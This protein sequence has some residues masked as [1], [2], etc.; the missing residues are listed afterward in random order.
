[1]THHVTEKRSRSLTRSLSDKFVEPL[2]NVRPLS[3]SFL[4]DFDK[5]KN[6]ERES[7]R[8]NKPPQV[9]RDKSKDKSRDHRFREFRS[10]EKSVEK[11]KFKYHS[12]SF[13]G[14]PLKD[15]LSAKKSSD[16]RKVSKQNTYVLQNGK[17]SKQL[18]KKTESEG[19]II[20]N[21][22][23]ENMDYSRVIDD[24]SPIPESGDESEN[25]Y[26]EICEY[27]LDTHSMMDRGPI[28]LP[29][30][31]LFREKDEVL[32]NLSKNSS[33]ESGSIKKRILSKSKSS[34]ESMCSRI[35]F[36]KRDSSLDKKSF[37]TKE[38]IT[39]S[40]SASLCGSTKINV[41]HAAHKVSL[42]NY[43]TKDVNYDSME[44]SSSGS[45][46]KYGSIA[47]SNSNCSKKY[48]SM[49]SSNSSS[50]KK[51]SSMESSNSRCSK[52]YDSMASNNSRVSKIS[53]VSTETNLIQ[54]NYVSRE[55]LVD[56]KDEALDKDK[57]NEVYIIRVV[58]KD[59]EDD[60]MST[61]TKSSSGGI[62]MK[63]RGFEVPKEEL[64]D[65]TS[66]NDVLGYDSLC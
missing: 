23:M 65:H 58:V 11:T 37:I 18:L 47:S 53:I 4:G 25:H 6:R 3:L 51:Y 19:S 21:R 42:D 10:R 62:Y 39:K 5:R 29:N 56:D 35:S 13:S 61:L 48:S 15:Q 30:L 55:S 66:G 12:G 33:K 32:S 34:T 38:L 49:E 63:I 45:S 31:S 54:D 64:G 24:I 1:V 59:E 7:S 17:N 9:N 27:G 50:S 28:S 14:F 20:S 36:G 41:V 26:A 40:R 22:S 43:I 60:R 46:K 57:I 2:A 52:N 8:E 16:S 44:S